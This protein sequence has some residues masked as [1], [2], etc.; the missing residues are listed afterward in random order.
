MLS[1]AF[2]YLEISRYIFMLVDEKSWC[3]GVCIDNDIRYV[4]QLGY[5]IIGDREKNWSFYFCWIRVFFGFGFEYFSAGHQRLI[6]KIKRFISLKNNSWK[7][8]F[9]WRVYFSKQMFF[10]THELGIELYIFR[11]ITLLVM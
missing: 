3:I 9:I 7:C 10:F 11:E 4:N 2:G 5:S 6:F 8:R 1:V